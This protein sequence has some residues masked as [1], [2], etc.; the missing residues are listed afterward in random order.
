MPTI[1]IRDGDSFEGAIRKFKRLIDKARILQELRLREFHLSGSVLKQR[2]KAAAKKRW[3]KKLARDKY[4]FREISKFGRNNS[5]KSP[6]K[7]NHRGH[8]NN[9]TENKPYKSNF[10]SIARG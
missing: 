7:D 2:Q 6:F 3:A 9:T 8:H 10:H 1:K 5:S 4:N